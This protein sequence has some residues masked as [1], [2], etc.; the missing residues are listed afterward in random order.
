MYQRF[1]NLLYFQICTSKTIVILRVTICNELMKLKK[2]F[3]LNKLSSNYVIFCKTKYKDNIQISIGNK[4]IDKV[5]ET[6]FLGVIIDD[7]LN[8]QSH[9]KQ[10]VTKLHKNYYII[11]KASRLLSMASLTMLYN[12]LCLPYILYCCEIWGRASA[13][14]LDEITLL[15]KKMIR[16][17]HKAFYREHT[18]PLFKLSNILMFLDLL[19]YAMSILM[20]KAFHNLLP[21]IIQN[22]FKIH[23]NQV[24]GK[25]CFP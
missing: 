12:S 7:Q 20:F 6:K 11:K 4:L 25:I 14:L 13:Y 15:Q 9:I 24:G 19:Q 1:L 8:W 17:V 18:K 16:L 3:A 5:S 21:A 2:W 23:I 10:I 22:I